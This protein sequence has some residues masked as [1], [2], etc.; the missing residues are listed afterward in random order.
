VEATCPIASTYWVNQDQ[1]AVIFWL[2]NNTELADTGKKKMN[3]L[4][5]QVRKDLWMLLLGMYKQYR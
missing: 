5:A 2:T 4:K 3:R 1:T